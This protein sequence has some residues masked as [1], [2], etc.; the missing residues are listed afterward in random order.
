MYRL[1]TGTFS[2]HT[3]TDISPAYATFAPELQKQQLERQGI[4]Q[5]QKVQQQQRQQEHVISDAILSDLREA[6]AKIVGPGK[7]G[8]LW[9]LREAI[10]GSNKHQSTTPAVGAVSPLPMK[11]GEEVSKPVGNVTAQQQAKVS[12]TNG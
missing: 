11:Q 7:K 6:E 8:A 4:F 3:V 9:G 12:G 1:T 10:W 5:D 2:S